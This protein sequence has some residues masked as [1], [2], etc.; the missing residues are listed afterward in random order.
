[1]DAELKE[2]VRTLLEKC[3]I[4][5]VVYVDDDFEY[6][7]FRE[8]LYGF[9][10]A[11]IDDDG[12]E[13]PFDVKA[14]PESAITACNQW[15]VSISETVIKSFAHG[16]NIERK[17]SDVE[18]FLKE[19]LPADSLSCLSADEFKAQFIDVQIKLNSE[20][21]LLILMDKVVQ[22]DEPESGMR[23]LRSFAGNENVACGLFSSKFMVEEELA[24]WAEFE[25]L[26]DIVYPLSKSRVNNPDE[27]FR[28]L[29]SVL[30]LRKISRI[31]GQIITIYKEAFDETQKAL[32][33][34][35]PASF[36]YA[37]MKTSLK[38][39][40]WE[41]DTL[42]R[43]LLLSLN[44]HFE[45]LM[46]SEAYF[47]EVQKMTK[48]LK[49]ASS[50]S[51]NSCVTDT[52]SLVTIYKSSVYEDIN[53]VNSTYSQIMNGDIFEFE[54]VGEYMLVCQPCNL[55]LRGDATRKNYDF[56]YMLPIDKVRK[57]EDRPFITKLHPVP[58]DDKRCVVL[59]DNI[60]INPCVLDVVCFNA[61]GEAKLNVNIDRTHLEHSDIMQD[62]ML[63]HYQKI[64]SAAK[65]SVILC[66]AISRSEIEDAKKASL[67]S[68]IT[69][70]VKIR[71]HKDIAF[72]EVSYDRNSGFIDFKIKRTK[73]YK[74][75][76]SQI[77]LHDF[78]NYLSRQALPNNFSK[79]PKKG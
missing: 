67:Q 79:P 34:M 38:E 11:H 26:K 7:L 56:V 39:G 24:Y 65:E 51:N 13:W 71:S 50:L 63:E 77:V 59:C 49:D 22:D 78:M 47:S 27:F 28:G 64:H 2:Q 36:D 46:V 60:R 69:A 61:N 72:P 31:K 35:D 16:H 23:L 55:E 9:I 17:E 52:E 74:E 21:R 3:H 4:T 41:F 42:K 40:C 6:E 37:V 19:V 76:Y 29:C 18:H 30:W 33:D 62:N 48:I 5:K 73:R 12:L 1:M 32:F 54:G 45:R 44:Q 66:E 43:I 25:G 70:T 8:P 15:M 14:G 57:K 58:E 75:P 10:R 68:L 53:Y 20:N